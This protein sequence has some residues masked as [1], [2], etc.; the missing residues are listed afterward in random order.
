MYYYD[1]IIADVEHPKQLTRCFAVSAPVLKGKIEYVAL[2]KNEKGSLFRQLH[3]MN[4]QEPACK[5]LGSERI[6][7]F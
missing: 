2:R 6:K 1:I 4:D 7:S 5:D 3:T